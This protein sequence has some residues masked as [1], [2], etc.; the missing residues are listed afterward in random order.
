M[1][2][3]NYIAVHAYGRLTWIEEAKPL[4]AILEATVD[5]YER[6]QPAP[7]KFEASDEFFG[8]MMKQIVGF[9]IA[10]VYSA[11]REVEI[12]PESPF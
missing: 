6:S 2:T 4:R 11:G 9:Q 7:G 8:K 10:Y 12:E 3:W 5:T 1:P